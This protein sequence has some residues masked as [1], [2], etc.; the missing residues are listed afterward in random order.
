MEKQA[1][2]SLHGGDNVLPFERRKKQSSVS[3]VKYEDVEVLLCSLCGSSNFML[4]SETTQIGCSS[5]GYL[6]GAQWYQGEIT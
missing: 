6:I 1:D 5:C 2:P 4:L 3:E